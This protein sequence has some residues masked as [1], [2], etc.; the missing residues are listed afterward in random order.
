MKARLPADVTP[1]PPGE[2]TATEF[3]DRAKAAWVR[4]ICKAYEADRRECPQYKGPMPV[5][6][7][8]ENPKVIQRIVEHLGLCAPLDAAT[9]P[10]HRLRN[11][12]NTRPRGQRLL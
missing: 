5:V 2:A 8:I 3:V 4:L 10:R 12:S 1:S 11:A 9:W 7:F 6:A